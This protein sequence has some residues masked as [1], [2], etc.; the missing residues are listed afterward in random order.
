MKSTGAI[1]LIRNARL[2]A[3]LISYY[4]FDWSQSSTMKAQAPYRERVRSILPYAIQKAIKASCGDRYESIGDVVVTRLPK[5]CHLDLPDADI[6]RAAATLRAMPG[7]LP[8]LTYQ[9]SIIETN[10]ETIEPT[11]QQ[12]AEVIAAAGKA[13][14]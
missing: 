4:S 9:L 14:P 12:L 7:L 2:R 11:Q 13:T 3:L 10:I 6:A 8:A 5:T 1:D